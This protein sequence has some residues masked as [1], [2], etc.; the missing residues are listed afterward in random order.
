MEKEARE[1]KGKKQNTKRQ[2]LNLQASLAARSPSAGTKGAGRDVVQF[3]RDGVRS[4]RRV[5]VRGSALFI[6]CPRALPTGDLR[7]EG[8]LE[9]GCER[10]SLV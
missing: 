6:L 8:A 9:G 5:Q 2:H 4:V 1:L 7:A 3:V 10:V